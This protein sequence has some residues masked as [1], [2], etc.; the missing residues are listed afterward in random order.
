MPQQQRLRFKTSHRPISGRGRRGGSGPNLSIPHAPGLLPPVRR[1]RPQSLPPGPEY[2]QRMK[3]REG[4]WGRRCQ[5]GSP[6]LARAGLC[7][8]KSK[9]HVQ[10]AQSRV[11]RFRPCVSRMPCTRQCSAMFTAEHLRAT[12]VKR[13]L[14]GQV[15]LS[16]R[17]ATSLLSSTPHHRNARPGACVAAAAA[18]PPARQ[19]CVQGWVIVWRPPQVGG[20]LQQKV[21]AR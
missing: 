12:H 19:G 10:C 3:R 15:R 1:R 14:L 21:H 11:V 20:R 16:G 5:H 17:H 18:C 6:L 8:L 7:N 2:R 4:R 9:Q 13:H